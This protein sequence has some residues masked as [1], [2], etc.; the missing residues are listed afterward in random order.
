[1]LTVINEK[2]FR[3]GDEEL[4]VPMKAL[5]SASNELPAK[6]Q[7]L[8]ALW[9]RFL[10]RFVVNGIEDKE[11]FN[12]M[13]SEKLNAYEDNIEKDEKITK[14]EYQKWGK[15]IDEINIPDNVFN[16]IHYIRNY[17]AEEYNKGK[18]SE[19]Q[20]YVSDRRWRKIVK[21]L[22]TSAFLNDRSEVDLMDCFLIKHCI[23]NEKEQRDTAFQYVSESIEKYGYTFDFDF[24]DIEEEIKELEEDIKKE[25]KHIKDNRVEVLVN[26]REKYYEIK[27]LNRNDYHTSNKPTPL[28]LLIS[29]YDALTTGDSRF[30]TYYYSSYYS[31]DQ[32]NENHNIRK[33]KDKYHVIID[34]SEYKLKTRI[35]GDRMQQTRKPHKSVENTWDNSV[36]TL[37]KTIDK[38][39]ND[40]EKYRSKD[41]EHIR[42]NIFVDSSLAI[43]VEKSILNT[44]ETIKQIE[45]NI[46][47]IQLNYKKLEDEEVVLN[48]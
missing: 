22:R 11:K 21:L 26:A 13:I 12:K 14:E 2:I 28:L 15:K 20:I 19:E 9:D 5:I 18:K 6:D 32:R 31:S 42:T 33:G 23:W 43:I 34:G 24:S 25:T 8:E 7:G 17:I 29:D 48:G 16:V 1:M 4:E 47:Q 45:S 3:N 36:V 46:K 30:Y 44:S 27:G 40:I 35:D 38:W 10:V 41:L 39:M 37:L